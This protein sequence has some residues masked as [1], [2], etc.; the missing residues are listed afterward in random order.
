MTARSQIRSER[1]D[2]ADRPLAVPTHGG[3][4]DALI[5]VIELLGRKWHPVIL[6]CLMTEGA[7]RFN[8]LKDEIAGVSSKVLS[9]S[10]DDLEEKEF[11]ERT[12]IEDRP[13]RVEYELTERGR[14]VR[15][16]LVAMQR[17]GDQHLG[18]DG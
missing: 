5:R 15:P 10:L 18:A 9:D 12:V 16:V 14:T 8:A 1:P 17:W 7:L 6:R 2:V 13:I 3:D 4:D 11:V